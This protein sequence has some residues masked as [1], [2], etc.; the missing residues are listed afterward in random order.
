MDYNLRKTVVIHSFRLLFQSQDNA[1][2][3]ETIGDSNPI[4]DANTGLTQNFQD[5]SVKE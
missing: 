2:S 3:K 4:K 1:S 5:M